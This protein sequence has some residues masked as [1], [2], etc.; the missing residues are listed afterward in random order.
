V[1][2]IKLHPISLEDKKVKITLLWDD[3]AR[4]QRYEFELY[5]DL[6]EKTA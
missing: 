2:R 5:K 6:A 1:G 4:S 3:N